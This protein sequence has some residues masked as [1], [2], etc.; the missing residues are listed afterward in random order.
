V[1]PVLLD[2]GNQA[3]ISPN[4]RLLYLETILPIVRKFVSAMELMTGYNIEAI[5]SNVS[6][7]QP[8]LKDIAAYHVGLVNGGITTAD[9]A[10]EELRYVPM[11]KN[12]SDE[13]RVPANIA[14][15]AVQPNVG[16]APKKPKP[17]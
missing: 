2:G 17:E 15:S 7:L 3:N 5:T 4:L 13:L 12:G 16:G 9:E 1:P 10:R 11:K 14:G 8:D 6:A